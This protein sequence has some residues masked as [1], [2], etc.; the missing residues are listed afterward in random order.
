MNIWPWSE[1]RRLRDMLGDSAR[2]LQ[3]ARNQPTII[4]VFESGR[5]VTM[6]FMRNG[7]IRDIHMV[8]TIDL[9]IREFQ[10]WLLK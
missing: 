9:D 1:L 7:E 8:R 10:K 5:M 3:E 4:S 6:R 2:L